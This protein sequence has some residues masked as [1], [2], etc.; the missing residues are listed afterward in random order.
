MIHAYLEPCSA[1]AQVDLDGR[2]TLW[3]ST[4]V[5][6]IVQCLLA[7]TMG[8]RENDVRVIKPYIGGV[9]AGKWNCAPGNSAP[10]LMAKKTGRPVKFTLSR[11]EEF[12]A[13]RRR[14]P[15]KLRS[16]VGFKKDGTLVAKD[17]RIQLDGGAYQCYGTHSHFLVWK[18]RG[19]ALSISQLPISW[20]ARI[21]EQ[22]ACKRYA[23]LRSAPSRCMPLRPK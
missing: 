16:K 22:A 15:M 19:H 8:M 3:T 23:R 7:S 17:L 6:Y 13:G 5:P 21:H 2:I 18:L 11:E 20:R 12:L 4:Q 14:H 10:R 1:L 9:L